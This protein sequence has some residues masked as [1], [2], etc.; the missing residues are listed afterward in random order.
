MAKRLFVSIAFIIVLL[1]AEILFIHNV[2]VAIV[3]QSVAILTLLAVGYLVLSN[4]IKPIKSLTKSVEVISTCDFTP[5]SH[6]EYMA[7]IG[8][9]A[10]Q[11]DKLNAM[12]NEKVGMSES[13]LA[14]IMTPM[15]VVGLDGN[16]RWLNESIVKLIEYDAEPEEFV[17][18]DFSTFF[19]GEKRET[20]SEKCLREKK[21]SFPR[22]RWKDVREIQS[23]FP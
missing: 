19:Y 22:G 13:M 2:A 6:D 12:L 23:I 3:L 20:V 16:I 21:S 10:I 18:Q 4:I 8:E 14:N 17:G 9:L 1:V 5:I 11:V 15:V 7:E